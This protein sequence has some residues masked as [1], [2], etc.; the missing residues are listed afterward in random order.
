MD[1]I[2]AKNLKRIL[3]EKDMTTAQLSR[4]T[5]IP[6]QTINNWLAGSEPRS[7]KQLKVVA[8]YLKISLDE[9]SY[10]EKT[11][12]SKHKLKEYEEEIFAGVFEVILRKKS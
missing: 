12:T 1:F 2:L 11:N 8:E 7:I 3:R 5:K 9:L 10:G 4:A 6:P